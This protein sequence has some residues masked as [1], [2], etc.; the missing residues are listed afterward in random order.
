MAKSFYETIIASGGFAG[1]SFDVAAGPA[2]TAVV[3][4]LLS[5]G[6]GILTEDAPVSLVVTGA[7]GAARELDLTNCE[8][9]GRFFYL[10]VRASDITT[11][12]LTLMVTTDINGMGPTSGLTISEAQDYLLVHESSGTW[13]A[14]QQK[15]TQGAD[16]QVYR[17]TFS[18]GDWAAGTANQITFVQTGAP[19]AGEVGPHSLGISSSYTVN[20][21]RD[22]DD[23]AVDVGVIVDG[24]TGNVTLT[25]TGLGADFA[26]RV[27]IVGTA[28]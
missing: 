3:D 10:S 17:A 2:N 22:S 20:V 13:R 19:G 8:Q 6:D 27:M 26:G 12:S 18:A 1:E 14:Y 7:L 28:T 23:E 25:K 24:G 11:N 9:D 4:V 5:A 16:S 15:L 21:Y